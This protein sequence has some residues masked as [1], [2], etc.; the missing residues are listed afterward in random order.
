MIMN[1]R[2]CFIVGRCIDGIL[3]V[4]AC[5]HAACLSLCYCLIA[6]LRERGVWCESCM[7]LYYYSDWMDWNRSSTTSNPHKSPPP[8][9]HPQLGPH[10]RLR[11]AVAD[12]IWPSLPLFGTPTDGNCQLHAW[13]YLSPT[14]ITRTV[15]QC[16]W[17][18]NI[19]CSLPTLKSFTSR[20]KLVFLRI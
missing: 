8:S 10:P 13:Q 16:P 12:T 1:D 3:Y 19:W 2:D 11:Y 18:Y 9:P 6:S 20:T 5:C 17:L 7:I 15:R 14:R 4:S